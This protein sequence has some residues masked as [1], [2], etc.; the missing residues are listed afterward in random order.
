[1]LLKKIINSSLIILSLMVFV[2]ADQA[3][4]SQNYSD[5][6]SNHAA[7]KEINFLTNLG[8]LNGYEEN[9]KMLY[10]PEIA[11]TRAEAA[12]MLIIALGQSPLTGSTSSFSDINAGT[13]E[14]G[15]IEKAVELGLFPT[16]SNGEFRPNEPLTYEEVSYILTKAFNLNTKEAST[17]GSPFLDVTSKS[18]FFEYINAAFYNGITQGENGYY[19]PNKS[20]T[21]EEF[22]LFLA[23]A[24]SKT[25]RLKLPAA[26]TARVTGAKGQAVVS[27]NDLNVRSTPNSSSKANIIGRVNKADI[28]DTFATSSGWVKVAYKGRYG[29]VSN[30]YVK[31]KTVKEDRSLNSTPTKVI[32]SNDSSSPTIQASVTTDSL[33]IRSGAGTSYK[34]IGKLSYGTNINVDS[35]SGNWIKITY[36]GVTGYVSKTYVKLLNQTDNLTLKNKIIILDAGHGGKDPGATK[37]SIYEKNITLTIT[38]LVVQKLEE[39]GATVFATR[40]GDTY[41]SLEQR[42]AFAKSKNGNAFVSIHVNAAASAAAS[43]TETYYYV[44]ANEDDRKDKYLASAINNEIVE[45]LDMRDRGIKNYPYYVIKN[46]SMP[47][48]LVELGFITNSNDLLKMTTDKNIDLYATSIYNGIEQYFSKY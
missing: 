36:N 22:A 43:G 33:N 16:T 30:K 15:Y 23:R 42:V 39:A 38:N 1:M 14:S 2:L 40:I 7:Y 27:V 35:I 46:T 24:K 25:Y 8:V 32:H 18:K 12:N 31:N 48:V 37:G 34:V 3:N 10:K 44:K 41:P 21:R 20:V 4:A 9:G 17:Y 47:S 11:V 13:S 45:N 26:P 19:C 29:Y 6:P 5:I 28:L